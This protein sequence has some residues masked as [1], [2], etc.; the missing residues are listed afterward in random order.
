MTKLLQFFSV[1]VLTQIILA[2]S[3]LVLLPI[4]IRLWG[5]GATAAWYSALA[6]A[7]ITTVVDCGLRTAGH[8]ELVRFAKQGAGDPAAREYFQQVWGWIRILILLMTLALIAGD[9]AFTVFRG[10][11]YPV[12]KAALTFAYALETLLIIRIMY[13]DTLGFYRG[14]EVS[15]L[16]FA[17]LRL[18]LAVPALLVLRLQAS[19]LAWLFLATSV[20]AIAFQ[21]RLLCRPVRALGAFAALPRRLSF[22]VLAVARHTLAE[23]CANWVR[24]SLPVLVI[25]TIATPAAVTTYV[26]LRA[27]FGVGRTTI[28][29]LARVA[30][31]EYLRLRDQGRAEAAESLLSIFVLA[32]GFLGTAIAS[33]IV[34][35]NMRVVGLWLTRFD[36]LTFQTIVVS[37]A[38]SA[39]FY[40]YQI[41]LALMFRVG[42]LAWAARRHYAY[43]IYSGLFAAFAL[44]AKWLPLYLVLLIVSELLLSTTFLAPGRRKM[45]AFPKRTGSRG[46]IGAWAGSV[47]VM[48]L[49]IAVRNNFGHIFADFSAGSLALTALILGSALT[50]F[51]AFSYLS[52]ADLFRTAPLLFR[53]RRE[54]LPKI[55]AN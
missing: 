44:R 26:A 17:A 31:V 23:P 13:L 27:A 55:Y 42:E 6:V 5:H 28:Q 14:A 47:V 53:R 18:V 21:G 20:V 25:A 33:F 35:D 40:A 39:A 43:T 45:L 41:I 30:S 52:N 51:A 7:T 37:F 49:W 4:Q 3:Q 29:Q 8:A 19:G 16:L 11:P 9:A 2:L 22:R 24:L 1:A 38:P 32:A 34:V 46:L 36:R 15:Y 10:S 12:W 54:A 48:T 50:G